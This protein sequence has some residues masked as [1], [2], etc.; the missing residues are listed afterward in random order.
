MA[1]AVRKWSINAKYIFGFGW[2]STLA[3]NKRQT[4]CYCRLLIW[5]WCA[6]ILFFFCTPSYCFAFA[7]VFGAARCN[8]QMNFSGWQPNIALTFSKFPQ[9]NGK[10]LLSMP[11]FSLFLSFCAT[12]LQIYVRMRVASMYLLRIRK[13]KCICNFIS[14]TEMSEIGTRNNSFINI[15]VDGP[16]PFY[17]FFGEST[18]CAE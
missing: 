5:I 7:L 14:A 11:F 12:G 10:F 16:F 9:K 4:E 2:G 13:T 1:N 3:K 18:R 6:F 8:H 17:L 15:K